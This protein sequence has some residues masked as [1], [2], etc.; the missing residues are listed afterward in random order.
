MIHSF[1][2]F[3]L[4]AIALCDGAEFSFS[5]FMMKRIYLIFSLFALWFGCQNPAPGTAVPVTETPI[6]ETP[7]LHRDSLRADSVALARIQENILDSLWREKILNQAFNQ[8]KTFRARSVARFKSD[9]FYFEKGPLLCSDATHL[10]LF[11][12]NRD[13]YF[14]EYSIWELNSDTIWSELLVL[15]TDIT[16]LGVLFKDLN[17]DGNKDFILEGYGA[18]GTEEKHLNE[19][20]LY[21]PRQHSLDY[22]ENMGMNPHFYPQEGVVTCYYNP[23]GVWSAEKYRLH[24]N[25]LELLEEIEVQMCDRIEEPKNM[26]C[27]R[28]IYRYRNGEKYLFKQ[29]KICAFPA[30]YKS[31]ETLIKSPE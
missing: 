27:D 8:L 6:A 7:I 30:E 17:G 18:S 10:L 19:V 16:T 5:L 28:N 15:E 25:K 1:F 3:L 4:R 29:D 9:S 2:R 13:G 26:C 12:R 21:N 24:W 23:L 11:L 14:G 20:Y 31:Y 22:I